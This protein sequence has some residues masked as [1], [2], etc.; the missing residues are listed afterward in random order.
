MR[1][2]RRENRRFAR[3]EFS[4]KVKKKLASFPEVQ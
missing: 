2:A 1:F 4:K 3:S